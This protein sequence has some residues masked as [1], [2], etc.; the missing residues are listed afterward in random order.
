M[1]DYQRERHSYVRRAGGDEVCQGWDERTV[2]R[3]MWGRQERRKS[4]KRRQETEY[5]GKDYQM[6]RWRSC[7]QHLTHD[8][9]KKRK[10]EREQRFFLVPFRQFVSPLAMANND[11][12]ETGLKRALNLIWARTVTCCHLQHIKTKLHSIRLVPVDD[13][14]V[15]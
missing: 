8:K 4:V 6:R 1:T 9:G 3:E 12:G 14:L 10:R 7:G 5:G 13:G 2:L 15:T 11:I